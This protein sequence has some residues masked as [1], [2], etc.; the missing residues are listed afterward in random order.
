MRQKQP[1]MFLHEEIFLSTPKN[2]YIYIVL[3]WLLTTRFEI[4]W[5]LMNKPKFIYPWRIHMKGSEGKEKLRVLLLL[6]FHKLQKINHSRWLCHRLRFYYNFI[7]SC[8]HVS[9]FKQCT[10]TCINKRSNNEGRVTWILWLRYYNIV[11]T[12]WWCSESSGGFNR[13]V[14]NFVF[15]FVNFISL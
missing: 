2:K 7:I 5:D 3:E 8:I 11:D 13:F 12:F 4:W 15:V 1:E 14:P 10:T 9:F 6:I